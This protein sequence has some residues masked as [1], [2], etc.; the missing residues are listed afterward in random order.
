MNKIWIPIL[1]FALII[2]GGVIYSNYINSK[3]DRMLEVAN[4]AYEAS[5]TDLEECRNYLEDAEAELEGISGLLCAFV[6]RDIINEA[7]DA[8]VCA[9]ALV[10]V[11]A[12]ECRCGIDMMKEKIEHIKNTAL[13]K[14]KYIL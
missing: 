7:K 4:K 14:L 13:I 6:D 12:D 8:I 1:I 2:G 5:N 9:E 11:G 3:T 10:D